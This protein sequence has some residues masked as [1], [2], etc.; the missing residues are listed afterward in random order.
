MAPA[1]VIPM[2]KTEPQH[3]RPAGAYGGEE[4]RSARLNLPYF[5]LFPSEWRSMLQG[6]S[7]SQTAICVHLHLLMLE[8]GR[9]VPEDTKRLAKLFYT[10]LDTFENALAD[11]LGERKIVRTD[12]GLWS[13][14]VDKEM[15]HR[16]QKSDKARAAADERNK[17]DKQNQRSG[18]A[19]DHRDSLG[20]LGSM[21]DFFQKNRPCTPLESMEPTESL[22]RQRSTFEGCSEGDARPT[23]AS[24]LR[25]P[26]RG[27]NVGDQ[28]ELEASGKWFIDSFEED[29][30]GRGRVRLRGD[31]ASDRASA[32]LTNDGKIDED[33][34]EID[35]G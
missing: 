28:I 18:S 10:R 15:T 6:L 27:Y 5:R 20:S 3:D 21:D 33:S 24:P 8:S 2:A 13:H 23:G 29:D 26:N 14:L 9:P 1:K 35:D 17:K 34:V 16:Q 22:G 11:L 30:Q 4:S 31:F 25:M 19:D 32:F 12:D 7:L